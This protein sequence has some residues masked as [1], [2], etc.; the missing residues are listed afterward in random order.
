MVPGYEYGSMKTNNETEIDL[1]FL[2]DE[3]LSWDLSE[4]GGWLG[5]R[6]GGDTKGWVRG[7]RAGEGPGR[8]LSGWKSVCEGEE[9][10]YAC[11]GWRSA[12]GWATEH[13][14]SSHWHGSLTPEQR[15]T[16]EVERG[17]RQDLLA[18]AE[19]GLKGTQQTWLPM[20]GAGHG[21][22]QMGREG[23]GSLAV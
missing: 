8:R 3:P 18:E 15:E 6:R 22:W 2:Q 11:G 21:W 12:L 5:E 20:G 10:S 9:E 16:I 17:I 23:W 19:N 1:G 14:L 7:N 4:S 13:L